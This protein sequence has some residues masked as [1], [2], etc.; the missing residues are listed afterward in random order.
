MYARVSV[1]SCNPR[2]LEYDSIKMFCGNLFYSTVS[3]T[4]VVNVISLRGITIVRDDSVWFN[5]VNGSGK[6]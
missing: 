1:N 3:E 2:V 5:Q 6:F 4:E